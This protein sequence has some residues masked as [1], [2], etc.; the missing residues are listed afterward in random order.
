LLPVADGTA[1]SFSI[2]PV[3]PFKLASNLKLITYTIIPFQTV[4][5]LFDGG[6]MKEGWNILF[7]GYFSSIQKIK[8]SWGLGP[9]CKFLPEQMLH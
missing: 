5:P 7:N 1:S 6:N 3:Y 8:L 2:Q 4:P 9:A